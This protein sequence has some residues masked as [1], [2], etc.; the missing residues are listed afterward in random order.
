MLNEGGGM[1][2]TTVFFNYLGGEGDL[3][4]SVFY[5]DANGNPVY[6]TPTPIRGVDGSTSGSSFAFIDLPTIERRIITINVFV[7]DGR[8]RT[9][10]LVS[11]PFEVL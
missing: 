9:S 7:T 11:T 3:A 2:T 5:Y 6:G 8:G 10:N 4:T 1:I